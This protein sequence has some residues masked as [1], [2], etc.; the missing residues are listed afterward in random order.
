VIEDKLSKF[1]YELAIANK[2]VKNQYADLDYYEEI[3]S[4]LKKMILFYEKLKVWKE[5][6]KV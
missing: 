1:R 3:I 4:H 2:L 6:G 5:I